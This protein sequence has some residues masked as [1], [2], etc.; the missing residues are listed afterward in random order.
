MVVWTISLPRAQSWPWRGFWLDCRGS[1]SL[2]PTVR[3]PS[4]LIR[5]V[6]AFVSAGSFGGAQLLQGMRSAGTLLCEVFLSKRWTT[7]STY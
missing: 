2:V 7:T 6:F 4:T 5:K 3:T 1:Q